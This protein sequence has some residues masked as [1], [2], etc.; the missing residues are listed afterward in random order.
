MNRNFQFLITSCCFLLI[1]S[2]IRAASVGC[3]EGNCLDG[4]GQYLYANG[5]RYIGDF[6]EG[7]P[8]GNGILY[9]ANGNKY[10]GQWVREW[11]QGRGRFIFREGHIYTGDFAQNRFEGQGIMEYAN[12]DRYEG[13]WSDNL[14]DGTGTYL[15]HDGAKYEGDFRK[16]RFH[17]TGVMFYTDGSLYR[18]HWQQS[19]MHGSGTYF[20]ADGQVFSGDW[21]FGRALQTTTPSHA[22]VEEPFALE[23]DEPA[24]EKSPPGEFV[25]PLEPDA[26]DEEKPAVGVRIWAVVVG[27][28]SYAHMP[29]LRYTDD[30]AY[31]FYAFLKSPE[32]GALPD[33]QVRV[34]VDDNAT[35]NNILT[36]MRET[37]LKAQE[38]DVVLFYFSGHGI[39]GAFI[40]ADFDG[41]NNRLYHTEIRD[42]LKASSARHKLVLGDACHAGT[43]LGS[44]FKEDWI[45]SS[46]SVEGMMDRYYRAFTQSGGGMALLL[47]SQGE[48]V[49]LEDSGL[50]S[51]VFSYYLIKGLKGAADG[52][53]DGIVTV[54][55][56]FDYV[57][58]QV[59]QY[60][61]G[62]QT[63]VL[64]GNFDEQMPMSVLRY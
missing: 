37:I 26:T 22:G 63:P 10:L 43:L 58:D 28:A 51:G 56:A 2:Q 8:H 31:Q 55:E 52:D 24:N 16:G 9:F 32:G 14:A 47:S 18:G 15:F 7:K 38:N 13:L 33:D 1:T 40:P 17:G 5:D 53:Q 39:Q 3:Q 29:S 34:L 19:K 60:T 62:A 36:A 30:D 6:H 49:S 61:A 54:E 4:Y 42:I 23:V 46:R 11:R 57:H 27:V 64:T 50:R 48:E 21:V 41:M 45:A 12:G 59:S 25:I 35:R 44:E 20:Q